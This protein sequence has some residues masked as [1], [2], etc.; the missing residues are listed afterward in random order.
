MLWLHRV[1]P[2]VPEFGEYVEPQL[3]LVPSERRG[4]NCAGRHL[5]HEW[6]G[7]CGAGWAQFVAQVKVSRHTAEAGRSRARP[8]GP[9]YGHMAA[10]TVAS[11][12]GTEFLL[13]SVMGILGVTSSALT[14]FDLGRV[15][16]FTVGES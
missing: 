13:I 6:V 15:G 7:S 14:F 3:L 10:P 1:E 5:R 4:A 11:Y 9:M 16:F 2:K 12:A 8:P